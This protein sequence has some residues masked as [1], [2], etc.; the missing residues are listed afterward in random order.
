MNSIMLS[1]RK[2]IKWNPSFFFFTVF[3]NKVFAKI[4]IIK[5]GQ[6]QHSKT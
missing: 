6:L 4:N 3:M 5:V 1:Q 2:S